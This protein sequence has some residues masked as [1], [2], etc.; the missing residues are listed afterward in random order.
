M[1]QFTTD[2]RHISGQ[3]NV[4]ADALFRVESVTAPP[5]Y[6]DDNS[7]ANGEGDSPANDDCGSTAN[8]DG[9]STARGDS[10]ANGDGECK[11]NGDGEGDGDGKSTPNDNSCLYVVAKQ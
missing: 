8:G 1:A 5:P 3:D 11:A 10:T 2:I 7:T 4:V 9:N 6:D